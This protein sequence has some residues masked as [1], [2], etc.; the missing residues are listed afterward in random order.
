MPVSPVRVAVAAVATVP[1]SLLAASV[2]TS[3]R[4]LR[5]LSQASVTDM[6]LPG[7]RGQVHVGADVVAFRFS[8]G[9]DPT[10]EPLVFVHGWGQSADGSWFSVL[11]LVDN[12]FVAIDLPG[13][14]SSDGSDFDFDS[15]A[16]ALLAVCDHVGF[17][18]P[19][20]V[21]HSMGGPVA[22]AAAK[23]APHRFSGLTLVATALDWAPVRLSLPLRTFP[24]LAARRSPLTL[25]RLR[26]QIRDVP[27]LAD[28]L[29]WAWRNPPRPQVLLR[30]A[31]S[32]REFDAQGWDLGGLPIRF[33]VPLDDALV[34]PRLQRK[35]ARALGAHLVEL[36]GAGHSFFVF[37]PQ[38]L[39]EHL[40]RT[41]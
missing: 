16:A 2:V 38:R 23:A 14:G 36:S 41:P 18:A 34:A 20:V 10:L 29:V 12:P 21:A 19:H 22:L 39:V 15:A 28:A 24:V 25:R 35:H 31:A 6:V 8:T 4:T 30:S 3:I 26:R 40:P 9:V 32:L 7:E 37:E 33:L 11:P 5:R 27:A 17:A 13:H 1:V